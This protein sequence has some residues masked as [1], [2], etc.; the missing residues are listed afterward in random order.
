MIP[1]LSCGDQPMDMRELKGLEIAARCRLTFDGSDWLVPSQ[2][3]KGTYRVTLNPPSCNCDDFA[4]TRQVCKHVHAARLVQ[5][6][7]HG[8]KQPAIVVDAAPKRP[9]Y[10]QNWPKYNLAQSI[11]KHRFLQLLSDLCRGIEEPVRDG[12]CGPKPHTLRDSVFA[13]AYKVYEG[14]SSRRFACDLQD[15]HAKGY[16]SRLIPGPKVCAFLVN[17]TLTPILQNLIRVSALPLRAV[18]TSFA[19]DSSGLSTS[20]FV[21]WYD[22]KYGIHR[23]GHDWVKVHL[24]SGTTT[25][26]VTAAAIYGRDANDSP[27]L[28]ELLKDT[29]AN[30]TVKE[31]PADKGY[32]SAE[33]VE[34]IH[35]AGGIPFIA[36]K[37]TTTGGI[38]GLFERMFHYYQFRRE[39]FL[40]HYHARSNVESVFS[41]MKRKFGDSIR[42]RNPVAMAN[43]VYAKVL[44]HN[45]C[46]LIMS[47]CEL[48]IEPVFWGEAPKDNAAVLKF[49]VVG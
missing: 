32:L 18:E 33:N 1:A 48:G 27:I 5:E 45:L 42:S 40:Q 34:A 16:L 3:G 21:R 20:K 10:Q 43:E 19:P 39:E 24:M 17:D 46:V 2:S 44:C 6:R 49:P 25:H 8:G 13:I 9:T 12:K 47:Q 29:A 28:P 15:A 37:T 11:E 30:F 38:G 31:V 23:S 36:P 26:I 14:F 41:M 4:L 35:A 22:E 7:D